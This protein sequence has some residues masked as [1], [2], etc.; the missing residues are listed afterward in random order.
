MTIVITRENEGKTIR[1]YLKRD[2]SFSSGFLKKLKAREGG[3]TVNGS[4]VTV[5]YVL[6]AG[7]TL[8]L[9]DED[10]EEDTSPY[11][12][13][14]DLPIRIAYEDPFVTVCD[15]PRAM[16]AHPSYS[17]RDDTVANALAYRYRNTP[18][19]F[20]PVNRLDGD[21]SGLML[22]ANDRLSAVKLYKA[23]TGGEIG[24][25]YV[26][27]LEKEPSDDMGV[28]DLH[29]KR[30]D[31][32]VITR[33][34]ASP[35]EEGARRAVTV[36]KKIYTDEKSGECAVIASPVT[37]RTH[38][39]RVHFSAI[40]CPIIGDYLYGT[41]DGRIRRHALHAAYLSFP[42]PAS[43]EIMHIYSPLADDMKVLFNESAEA[44]LA[45]ELEKEA[46]GTLRDMYNE[47]KKDIPYNGDRKRR[48]AKE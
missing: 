34:V 4:F 44:L 19:V 25:M 2:L 20:R 42:H 6:R 48:K 24:K 7:D 16:P 5:R 15:K 27:V 29:M 22:T 47:M 26:A 30:C 21:T 18:Y 13:P 43:G 33:R 10:R 31:A 14:V 17:H 8:C 35:K 38:Q 40:G 37:G 3:I 12:F 36:Y 32:S 1:D 9:A 11:I 45:R 41:P 28:I 46:F 23:M 39:L